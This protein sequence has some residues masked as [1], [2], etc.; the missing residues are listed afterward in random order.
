MTPQNRKKERS[1]GR[2]SNFRGHLSTF[3]LVNTPKSGPLKSIN[4][5]QTL[6]KQAQNNF[7]KF[8][9]TTF[10]S[11]DLLKNDPSKPKNFDF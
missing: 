11:P 7:E 2:K 1:L 6:L 3:Q 4:N 10:L 5:T 8:Q 9:K